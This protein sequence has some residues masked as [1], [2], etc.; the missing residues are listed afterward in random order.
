MDCERYKGN[1]SAAALG[2][3]EPRHEA[4]FAAHLAVCAACRAALDDEQ[5][6]LEAIDRGVAASV[7]AEPTAEFAARLRRRLDQERLPTRSW[8]AGWVPVAAGALAIL[9][10]VALWLARRPPILPGTEPPR[11]AGRQQGPPSEEP[12][13]AGKTPRGG[14]SAP[15]FEQA[16][17]PGGKGSAFR[18]KRAAAARMA[19]PEVLVPPGQREAVLQFY[20]AVGSGRVD[21]ASLLAPPP[22]LEPA[23]LKIVPLE[24]AKLDSDS[25]R[26]SEP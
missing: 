5:G 16:A 8:F 1:L 7:A 12:A 3:P 20:N 19:V 26:R 25:D 11:T 17:T 13:R 6:L 9:A 14:R 10:L 23:K 22:P 4:E 15:P 2:E 21:S 24:V 18:G